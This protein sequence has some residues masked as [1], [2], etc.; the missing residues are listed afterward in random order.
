MD[1]KAI[2][3]EMGVHVRSLFPL[4]RY[5]ILQTETH[6]FCLALA[7]AALIGFYPFCLLLLSI[8]RYLLNWD[9]GFEVVLQ[10]IRLYFP[11]SQDWLISNLRASIGNS[12]G[13][14]EL[15]S[16]FW[17][18]LGAAGV[19]VPLEAGLNRLWKVQEDRTYW[20]NQLLG[21]TLTTVCGSMALCFVAINAAIQAIIHLPFRPL[22]PVWNG[23]GVI[24][25]F[26]GY[27]VL[28]ITAVV[29][30][31]T[32]ILLFYKFLPNRQIETQRV[33][34]AAILAGIV[35]EIVKD[36]YILVL[37]FLDIGS[38]RGSQGPFHVS[39]SFVVLAYFET[40]VV[41]GGAFLATQTESYPWMGF[42]RTAW[43]PSSAPPP[44]SK[45]NE[46]RLE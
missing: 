28:Q 9:G 24:E 26:F 16:I 6:A 21:L 30:F 23:F 46:T 3:K 37:P 10:A 42:I 12:S 32:A 17:V 1:K 35:A 41:L 45:I 27:I 5:L 13:R 2:L 22:Q 36:I 7:C 40:F 33:L 4:F 34:P 39:V 25:A 44:D 8:M 29:F 15:G 20:R 18:F 14:I 38:I 11:N 43:K 19:F 31:S